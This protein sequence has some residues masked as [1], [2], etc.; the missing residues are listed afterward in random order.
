[1]LVRLHFHGIHHVHQ[2]RAA[3]EAVL[4]AALGSKVHG[5]ISSFEEIFCNLPKGLIA[6]G[7]YRDPPF[8]AI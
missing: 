5:V 2:L 3:L 4:A 7:T 6:T 1:M 8:L